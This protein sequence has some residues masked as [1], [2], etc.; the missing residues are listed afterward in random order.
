MAVSS[1]SI[2]LLAAT[3]SAEGVLPSPAA[4]HTPADKAMHNAAKSFCISYFLLIMPMITSPTISSSFIIGC[5][6]L[7][8][9]WAEVGEWQ[10]FCLI[11]WTLQTVYRK[12]LAQQ[13][14]I[15]HRIL[16]G[17]VAHTWRPGRGVRVGGRPHTD[18]FLQRQPSPTAR[19]GRLATT[20]G[21][22]SLGRCAGS[23]CARSYIQRRCKLQRAKNARGL[24]FAAQ[25]NRHLYG[26]G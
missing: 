11:R 6:R 17:F 24:V 23:G 1:W 8:G 12:R 10:P 19:E 2:A 25:L 16:R 22:S 15:F 13:K 4:I 7:D 3:G 5:C 14:A 18:F 20:P 26:R 21:R 9:V